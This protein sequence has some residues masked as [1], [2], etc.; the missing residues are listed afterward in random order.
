MMLLQ[1]AGVVAAGLRHREN[2]VRAMT[3]ESERWTPPMSRDNDK[4]GSL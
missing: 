4:G 3:V 2:L 1:V